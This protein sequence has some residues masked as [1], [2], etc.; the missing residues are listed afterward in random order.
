[1]Q[2]S[3]LTTAGSRRHATSCATMA[4]HALLFLPP[5]KPCLRPFPLPGPAAFSI[6][7]LCLYYFRLYAA[8]RFWARTRRSAKGPTTQTG[9]AEHPWPQAHSWAKPQPPHSAQQ[10]C[11][12]GPQAV[13]KT[14]TNG[15]I[16]ESL[17]AVTG[18]VRIP[19]GLVWGSRSGGD[20]RTQAKSGK[21]PFLTTDT[22]ACSSQ[23][24]LGCFKCL[25]DS[26][27]VCHSAIV[28]KSPGEAVTSVFILAKSSRSPLKKLQDRVIPAAGIGSGS[29]SPSPQGGGDQDKLPPSPGLGGSAHESFERGEGLNSPPPPSR[30]GQ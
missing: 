14:K 10:P 28:G 30:T 16:F 24:G 17:G 3:I 15:R 1:M 21:V 25:S 13:Y 19:W 11:A 9:T 26:H 22:A 7:S 8:L 29:R 4:V 23:Y 6:S 2:S 27:V 5:S 18:P 12:V 20:P